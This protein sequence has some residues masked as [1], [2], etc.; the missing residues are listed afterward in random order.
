MGIG[1]WRTAARWCLD[2]VLKFES[3]NFDRLVSRRLASRTHRR[4][5]AAPIHD[6]LEIT[7]ARN[8]YRYLFSTIFYDFNA[9]VALV[10]CHKWYR[11][12]EIAK[13]SQQARAR[14]PILALYW[15]CTQISSVLSRRDVKS[16]YGRTREKL[17]ESSG[18]SIR[19]V[20]RDDK[21]GVPPRERGTT[22][23]F[24]ISHAAA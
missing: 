7:R 10:S 16:L 18:S 21:R 14:Q 12:I 9:N 17:S 15:R 19:E 2:L 5:S 1:H 23:V 3:A 6:R 13:Y 8:K 11:S 24:R 20:P 22:S 4:L